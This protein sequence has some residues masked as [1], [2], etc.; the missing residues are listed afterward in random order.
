MSRMSGPRR[1]LVHVTLV[2][3]GT[4]LAFLGLLLIVTDC[5]TFEDT[6]FTTRAANVGF[7]VALSVAVGGYNIWKALTAPPPPGWVWLLGV[8]GG[9]VLTVMVSLRCL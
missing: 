8:P 4:G 3:L 9:L 1:R 2:V 6:V 5:L 7:A